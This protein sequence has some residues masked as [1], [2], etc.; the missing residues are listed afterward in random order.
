MQSGKLKEL[1]SRYLSNDCTAAEKAFVETWY[2]KYDTLNPMKLSEAEM[3]ADVDAIQKVLSRVGGQSHRLILWSR[4]S[5]AA[6]VILSLSALL[7]LYFPGKQSPD[8]AHHTEADIK[9]GGDKAVLTLSDGSKI[10]L[11]DIKSGEIAVQSGLKISKSEDGQIVYS[12]VAK[13]KTNQGQQAPEYNTIETPRGGKFQIL[14]PDGSLVWLDAASS[15]KY[16]VV[17]AGKERKVELSGQAY[18]EV[19]KSKGKSFKVLSANQEVE[20][21]G[22]HFN[23][24]AYANQPSVITTL[25]EGSV[26]V[27]LKNSKNSKSGKRLKPGQQ[28]ALTG[29]LFQVEE[30]D[31]EQAVAWKNGY[32]AF[33]RDDVRTVLNK[34][35]RWYDVEISSEGTFDDIKIGGKISRTKS[36]SEVLRVLQL[37]RKI[38]FKTEGRR[39]IAMP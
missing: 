3:E 30:V 13:S 18:F 21:L 24:N 19:A 27:N 4:I 34:L 28:A 12:S 25:L 6:L 35:E 29:Q 39:I 16:P 33:E 36:L 9:A 26:N 14:L 7:Y 22:T 2:N 15:L 1:L 23:V 11:T 38:K 10:S 8:Y 32:F 20:V 17:F 5:A 37:T 31:V